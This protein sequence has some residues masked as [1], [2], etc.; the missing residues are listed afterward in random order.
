MYLCIYKP[1]RCSLMIMTVC[2]LSG[3]QERATGVDGAV[4]GGGS[5][6]PC[7]G[8]LCTLDQMKRTFRRVLFRIEYSM[9]EPPERAGKL[10]ITKQV[11]SSAQVIPCSIPTHFV[12]PPS[13]SLS[14]FLCLSLLCCPVA[15]PVPA[16][17]T[18]AM[19]HRHS[20]S[21]ESFCNSVIP[22]L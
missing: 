4:G 5:T 2:G 12:P 13:L 3:G 20:Q 15:V 17:S 19:Y 10:C 18:Y 11:H 16:L 9:A 22:T 7:K 6:V 8:Q 21:A 14:F 1:I